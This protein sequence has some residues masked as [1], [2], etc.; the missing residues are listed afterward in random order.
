MDLAH[1]KLV[2]GFNVLSAEKGEKERPREDTVTVDLTPPKRE[3]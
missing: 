1:T 2:T 3:K